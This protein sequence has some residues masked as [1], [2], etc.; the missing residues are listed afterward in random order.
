MRK[1]LY[2]QLKA[3]V[4]EAIDDEAAHPKDYYAGKAA[5]RLIEE[6]KKLHYITELNFAQVVDINH[7]V[8]THSDM[9]KPILLVEFF[10]YF[11]QPKFES[12]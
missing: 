1:N 9:R 2:E 10:D 6:L 11:E 4:R 5:E 3:H 12:Q 8:F 7:I